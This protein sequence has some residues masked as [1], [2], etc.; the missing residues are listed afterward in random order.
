[1]SRLSHAAPSAIH[2]ARAA[3]LRLTH[4]FAAPLAVATLSLGV[5]VTLAMV[6]VRLLSGLA[7]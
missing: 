7:A 6:S 4:A 2:D 5:L 3:G 1:M